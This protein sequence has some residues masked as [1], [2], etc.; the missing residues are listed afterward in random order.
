MSCDA[1]VFDD[2]TRANLLEDAI[3]LYRG[4]LLTGFYIDEAPEFERW[5]Q[6]ERSRLRACAARAAYAMSDR[7]EASGDVGAAFSMAR[8]SFELADGDER[9]FRRLIELQSRTGDRTGAL[10]A[11]ETF[12]QRLA[13]EFQT[14]PSSETKEL[15]ERIR[16]DSQ[17]TA[18]KLPRS[19]PP[20]PSVSQSSLAPIATR[21]SRVSPRVRNTM[22]GAAALAV[23]IYGSTIWMRPGGL[24]R[25]LRYR[26]ALDSTE[27]IAPGDTW[28]GRLAISPD[29]SRL[30]YIGG[31]H[32][33]L[34]VRELNLLHAV[35]IPG[36]EGASTPF[37]RLMASM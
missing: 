19:S 33:Q 11:Y 29:G 6:S 28:A 2:K 20:A 1:V 4:D 21:R 12:A 25:V 36:T 17:R 5:L 16:S 27:A 9:G 22:F 34:M 26:L 24:N 37:S 8:R 15:V 30:A 10:K 23:L 31:P 14:E 3:E 32:A 13:Q 7:L 18:D 35:A